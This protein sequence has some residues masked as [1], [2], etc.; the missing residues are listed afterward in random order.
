M[1]NTTTS[2]DTRITTMTNNI[3]RND[4]VDLQEV[5]NFVG[6]I[7]N[8]VALILTN[9]FGIKTEARRAFDESYSLQEFQNI[10]NT[11]LLISYF[12]EDQIFNSKR[13][14]SRDFYVYYDI[15]YRV[16]AKESYK[17]KLEEVLGIV[18]QLLCNNYVTKPDETA[19]ELTYTYNNKKFKTYSGGYVNKLIETKVQYQKISEINYYLAKQNYKLYVNYT[20]I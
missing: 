3:V 19:D 7:L 5:N 11:E 8:D 16:E 15:Y 1:S 6:S 9:D 17:S 4:Y 14:K 13:C 20:I 12:S 18:E 10:E 2:L